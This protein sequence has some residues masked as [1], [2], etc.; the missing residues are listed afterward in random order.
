M[1]TPS[2]PVKVLEMEKRS[3][4]TKKELAQRKKAEEALLTGVELREKKEVKDNQAA[5]KEFLR[6]KKLLKA[7]GKDDDLYGETINRYCVLIAECGEFQQ[8]REKIYQ[9]LCEFQERMYEL[10]REE[11]MSWR[12]AYSLEA[13]MQRNLLSIDRQVQTKRRML[14]DM[15][16][17]NIMTIAASLR[18]V[19]KRAEPKKNALK[20]ALL[21]G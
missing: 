12:E 15:E 2:K 17:E 11:E 19:P 18:S 16:K 5:H 3:H 6:L 9:Q 8:K 20:E 4:R 1:P 14:L 21:S 13:T 7:I 10:V